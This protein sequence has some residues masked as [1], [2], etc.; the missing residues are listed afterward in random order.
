[1]NIEI[2]YLAAP[3][4]IVPYLM[5]YNYLFLVKRMYL[6]ILEKRYIFTIWIGIVILTFYLYYSANIKTLD[7]LGI[8]VGL[9]VLLIAERI[10]IKHRKFEKYELYFR[11]TTEVEDFE[12]Y[13]LEFEQE[14]YFEEASK[15]QSL[16]VY[17]KNPGLERN[18]LILEGLTKNTTLFQQYADK[19][20]SRTSVFWLVFTVLLMGLFVYFLFTIQIDLFSSLDS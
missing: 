15:N 18:I 5:V 9:L 19:N 10:Y 14:L 17:F 8:I 16:S 12:P 1:M 13:A 11:K 4:V 2:L 20:R 7:V 3:I 6:S